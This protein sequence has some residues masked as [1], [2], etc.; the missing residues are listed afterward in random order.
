MKIVIIILSIYLAV[1]VSITLLPKLVIFSALP[2]LILIISLL[3]LFH[4]DLKKSLIW[5][6]VGGLFLDFFSTGF[7]YNIL[8]TTA[9]VLLSWYLIK[10]FFESS[11]IYLFLTFCFFS[12]L[13]YDSLFF[14]FNHLSP[15]SFNLLISALYSTFLGSILGIVY[16]QFQKRLRKKLNL[17]YWESNEKL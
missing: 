10:R 12:S 15:F 17:V 11:N 3:F 16:I 5:A 4:N 1:L 7:P 13:L 2:K 9:I 6:S 8:F 14:I